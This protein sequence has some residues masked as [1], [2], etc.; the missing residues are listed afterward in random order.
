MLQK[1]GRYAEDL[2]LD[3]LPAATKSAG[4]TSDAVSTVSTRAASRDDDFIELWQVYPFLDP[5][6]WHEQ[7]EDGPEITGRE[8]RFS[9]VIEPTK[10]IILRIEE[11]GYRNPCYFS[12]GYKAAPEKGFW[13]PR[14][15][16][17][18]M[19]GPHRAY[20]C[21]G[22]LALMGGAMAVG[23]PLVAQGGQFAKDQEYGPFEY[24]DMESGTLGMPTVSVDLEKV[25]AELMRIERMGLIMEGHAR[26]L[27]AVREE[28]GLS[29]FSLY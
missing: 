14:S 29:I 22:N 17:S 19:E 25:Q 18:D 16:G 23:P 15:V 24:V 11:Y 4:N 3:D 7:G 5:K 2:D 27:R 20:Q 13:N 6:A 28:P 1:V 10:Q 26:P 12:F 9:I 8:M 21:L